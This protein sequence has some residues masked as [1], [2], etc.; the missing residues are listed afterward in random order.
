MVDFVE[1]GWAAKDYTHLSFGGGRYL[2][3]QLVNAL[4]YLK[5]QVDEQAVAEEADT[6]VTE[7]TQWRSDSLP[8]A[9]S[10]RDE[11]TRSDSNR[12]ESNQ[13][14]TP[15]VSAD[16]SDIKADSSKNRDIDPNLTDDDA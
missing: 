6:V 14:I 8:A 7:Q 16:R 4:L 9:R 12:Y 11:T 15:S 3:K 2:A 5:Q 13:E 10:D 1:K